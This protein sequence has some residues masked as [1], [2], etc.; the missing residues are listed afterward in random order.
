MPCCPPRIGGSAYAC[1]LD[2]VLTS[3]TDRGI[4]A[5]NA[6]PNVEVR[7]FNPFV[8]RNWRVID[9]LTGFSRVNRR[10]H[11]KILHGG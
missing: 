7:L 8:R 4:A 3:G 2:D 5:L 1:F 6:H 10:M 11:N 9:G